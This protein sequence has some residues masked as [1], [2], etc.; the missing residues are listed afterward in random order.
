[1]GEDLKMDFY[2]VKPLTPSS[3]KPTAF[4]VTMEYESED[5]CTLEGLIHI[6][7][8]IVENLDSSA[9]ARG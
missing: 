8:T 6:L 3:E 2:K 1:M 7:G 4:Y 5:A 9:R